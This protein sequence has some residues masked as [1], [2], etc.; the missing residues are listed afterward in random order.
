MSSSA[1]VSQAKVTPVYTS[2]S[3]AINPVLDQKTWLAFAA[4]D[5]RPSEINS[6]KAMHY[7]PRVFQ[8]G[9][10]CLGFYC[11]QRQYRHPDFCSG[12]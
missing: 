8:S 9:L 6:H 10:R 11:Q 2:E 3:D 12:Y 7:L 4:R 5:F 1:P